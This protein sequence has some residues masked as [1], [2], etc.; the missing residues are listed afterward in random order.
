MTTSRHISTGG[1]WRR[2]LLGLAATAVLTMGGMA[3]PGSS[4][5]AVAAAPT[6]DCATA[7]PQADI[8]KGQTVTTKTVTSGTTP[9]EFTGTVLG[10]VTDGIAPGTDMVLVNFGTDAGDTAIDKAGIWEGMSGSPVYAANGQIIGAV[11]YTL[12]YGPSPVAGVTPFP[13]MQK[14]L[15]GGSTTAAPAVKAPAR[16]GLSKSLAAQ[17]AKE[18]DV[19]QAQA[20][21]GMRR[22]PTPVAIAGVSSKRLSAIGK[23]KKPFLDQDFATGEIGS[24]AATGADAAA[25]PETLA[26]GGNIAAALVYGDITE[27]GV[28][29]VTS[30]CDGGLV[31]FGHPFNSTGKTT[32]ALMTADATAVLADSLGGSYKQANIGK[33]AGVINQDRTPAIAGRLGAGPKVMKAT[34][35]SS[36]GTTSRTGTSYAAASDYDADAAAGE[37]ISNNDTVLDAWYVKGGALASY[38]VKGTDHGK[39]FTLAF[40]DRYADTF[41]ISSAAGYPI[42]DLVY[43]LSQ[44]SGVTLTSVT[45]TSAFNDTYQTRKLSLVE[46][47]KGKDWVKV[48]GKSP[49]TV[50]AGGKAVL[51][52]TLTGGGTGPVQQRVTIKIPKRFK[53]TSGYVE[54]MGGG[55]LYTDLYDI[56]SVADARTTLKDAVRSDAIGLDLA[57]RGHGHKLKKSIELP[58]GTRVVNGDRMI[59][60]LVSTKVKK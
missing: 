34:A 14:Y 22:L 57:L 4:D 50:K 48:T 33:V 18:T 8:A 39:A 16:V 28:G 60:F 52:F 49:I 45:T 36:Y 12:T 20:S 55:S 51:R 6:A 19:S 41:D 31:A 44:L 5:A 29:T 56:S 3:L 37:A 24:P 46:Q 21:E 25:G 32:M 42:G 11:S 58:P 35:T 7:F 9:E 15:P 40:S 59:P 30:V 27:A 23:D 2:P 1:S 47:K 26:A 54:V 53:G 43:A 17:V 38:T 10:I 13:A